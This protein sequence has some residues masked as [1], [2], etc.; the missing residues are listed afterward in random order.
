VQRSVP[1]L[2]FSRDVNINKRLSLRGENGLIRSAHINRS[3][4]K[5]I[6]YSSYGTTNSSKRPPTLDCND[7]LRAAYC[8]LLE[9]RRRVRAAEAAIVT[10]SSARRRKRTKRYEVLG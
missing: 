10:R 4:F 2:T 3:V 7:P 9:L 5:M 1:D 8:E 6:R